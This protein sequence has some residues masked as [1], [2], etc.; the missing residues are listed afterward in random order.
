[1]AKINVEGYPSVK[2]IARDGHRDRVDSKHVF[3]LL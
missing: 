3:T 2:K 1:V